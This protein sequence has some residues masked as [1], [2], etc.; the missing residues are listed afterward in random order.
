MKKYKLLLLCSILSLTSCAQLTSKIPFMN[1]ETEESVTVD[2]GWNVA[3]SESETSEMESEF[4]WSNISETQ[5]LED[6]VER[7]T[8]LLDVSSIVDRMRP[9]PEVVET[10]DNIEESTEEM[11]KFVLES[12]K[13]DYNLYVGRKLTYDEFNKL[14]LNWSKVKYLASCLVRNGMKEEQTADW[15]TFKSVVDAEQKFLVEDYSYQLLDK[16]STMVTQEYVFMCWE[17]NEMVATKET[18]QSKEGESQSRV[19]L[20]ET[21]EDSRTYYLEKN[22]SLKVEEEKETIDIHDNREFSYAERY[23]ELFDFKFDYKLETTEP[24][25]VVG[26][27][28]YNVVNS[29][30]NSSTSSN[31]TSG[32]TA[33]KAASLYKSN[34]QIIFNTISGFTV[35]YKNSNQVT[36]KSN[37]KN[38]ASVDCFLTT[39]DGAAEYLAIAANRITQYGAGAGSQSKP[40]IT[41]NYAKNITRYTYT[42]TETNSQIDVAF[43][44]EIDNS[45]AIVVANMGPSNTVNNTMASIVGAIEVKLN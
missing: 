33:A 25:T 4:D 8:K 45:L 16:P 1:K 31:R 21:K 36:Y 20:Q 27:E 42:V 28:T 41:N 3:D 23:P 43:V 14:N 12:N 38:G 7:D 26:E 44:V 18:E 32:T 17:P 15:N 30:G 40:T 13:F 37:D 6:L 5:V 39:K 10:S 22:K 19:Y 35:M 24:T 34:K 11:T 29:G 9:G 2:I